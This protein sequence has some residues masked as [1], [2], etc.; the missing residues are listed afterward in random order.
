ML[1]HKNCYE[2]LWGQVKHKKEKRN[3]AKFLLIKA[4]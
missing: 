2:V 1:K 4:F 3:D